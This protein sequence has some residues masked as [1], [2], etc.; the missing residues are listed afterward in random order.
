MKTDVE[1]EIL[2]RFKNRRGKCWLS[3]MV[4]SKTIQNLHGKSVITVFESLF[5]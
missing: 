1:F 3:T 4:S 2:S 5:L